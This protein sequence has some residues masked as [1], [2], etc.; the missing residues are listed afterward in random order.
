MSMHSKEEWEAAFA[1]ADAILALEGFEKPAA[2]ARLQKAVSEGRLTVAEA[3]EQVIS[4]ST[5]R[6]PL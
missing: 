3:V 1:R 2:V 4:E 6:R 5:A